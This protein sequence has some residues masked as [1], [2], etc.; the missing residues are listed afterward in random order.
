VERALEASM[1][2]RIIEE[3]I[4]E[5]GIAVAAGGEAKAGE[6]EPPVLGHHGDGR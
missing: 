1:F 3:W 4:A 5:S 2:S 6:L